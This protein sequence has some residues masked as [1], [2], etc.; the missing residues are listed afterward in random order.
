M[1][2]VE[3]EARFEEAVKDLLVTLQAYLVEIDPEKIQVLPGCYREHYFRFTMDSIAAQEGR[4]LLAVR[5]GK[6]VGLIA[7]VIETKDDADR[8]TN[9][10]PK[11]GRITELVVEPSARGSGAGKALL[12]E[13][14]A[15][16]RRMG[17]AYIAIDVF[18]P[19]R[20]ALEFYR[21][22]GYEIRNVEVMK[23]V[24]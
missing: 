24:R 12:R 22:N 10:C 6:A 18:G 2:I 1:E 11:R 16:L 17:C 20:N 9:R 14:E 23:K 13:M 8:L 7:G 15:C 3:Y 4:L 19:N 21:R 5:H